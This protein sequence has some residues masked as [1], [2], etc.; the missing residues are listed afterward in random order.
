MSPLLCAAI[1]RFRF[2][3]FGPLYFTVRRPSPRANAPCITNYM[4]I[5]LEKLDPR[6]RSPKFQRSLRNS[7]YSLADYLLLPVLWIV[8]T[9]IFLRRLGVDQ[10]GIWMLV[11]TVMGF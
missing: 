7:S 11:N 3:A 4:R 2:L 6:R 8:A 10:Y 5:S 1:G 9:P